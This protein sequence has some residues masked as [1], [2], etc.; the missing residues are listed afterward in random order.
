MAPAAPISTGSGTLRTL[1]VLP[2]SDWFCTQQGNEMS[3][4]LGVL[5]EHDP[6]PRVLALDGLRFIAAS[7]VA[8]AHYYQ[9]IVVPQEGEAG[10]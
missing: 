7:L 5:T 1:R 6:A 9:W 3:G 2:K 4:H 10:C 8:I